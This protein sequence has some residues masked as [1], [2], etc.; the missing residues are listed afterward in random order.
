MSVSVHE[1]PLA[2]PPDRGI[3]IYPGGS[4]GAGESAVALQRDS[5]R[6]DQAQNGW[7]LCE[8]P[9]LESVWG[10]V[11][12]IGGEEVDGVVSRID[13]PALVATGLAGTIADPKG[14][15]VDTAIADDAEWARRGRPAATVSAPAATAAARPVAMIFPSGA[16][17]SRE[18]NGTRLLRGDVSGSSPKP[19]CRHVL[20]DAGSARIWF[21]ISAGRTQVEQRSDHPSGIGGADLAAPSGRGRAVGGRENRH[22]PG[23]WL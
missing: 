18:I 21:G 5:G 15:V 12:P 3:V 2:H 19:L 8:P 10:H 16:F 13:V 7:M 20:R 4:G 9:R 11:R 17:S 6:M 23:R 22:P 14:P 1:M